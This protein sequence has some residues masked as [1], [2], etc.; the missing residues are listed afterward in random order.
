VPFPIELNKEIV[1]CRIQAA[2]NSQV[3]SVSQPLDLRAG[4]RAD[5]AALVILKFARSHPLFLKQAL[6]RR[7]N[8]GLYLQIPERIHD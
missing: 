5:D 6:R 8:A 4:V 3:I 2:A 7:K 1:T